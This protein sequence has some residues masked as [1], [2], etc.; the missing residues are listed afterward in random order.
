[1]GARRRLRTAENYPSLQVL[2][3]TKK[4]KRGSK[5]LIYGRLKKGTV[6]KP[7]ESDW[8]NWGREK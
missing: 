1:L 2:G 7:G 8:S 4:D 6:G 5:N 3:G